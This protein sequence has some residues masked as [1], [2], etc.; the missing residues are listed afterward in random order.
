MNDEGL[1]L[2]IQRTRAVD[3]IDNVTDLVSSIANS[4]KSFES[5]FEEINKNKKTLIDGQ[6]K[7]P[8]FTDFLAS[9]VGGTRTARSP[10]AYVIGAIKQKLQEVTNKGKK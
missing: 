2:Y 6:E 7:I 8:Y 10:K 5:D 1:N 4:P 9:L 3:V